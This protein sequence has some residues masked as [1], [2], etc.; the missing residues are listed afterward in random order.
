MKNRR[1]AYIV[2][3]PKTYMNIEE[4]R[5]KYSTD[6]DKNILFLIVPKFL[7]EEYSD[8]MKDT[9]KEK[10][11]DEIIW[12]L[13]WSN[14]LSAKQ[15]KRWYKNRIFKLTW[16]LRETFFNYMDRKNIDQIAHKFAPCDLVFSAHKNT[17]EHLAAKLE[18]VKL[19]LVD[20]GQRIFK[21]INS[22]G[23]IDYSSRYRSL[24]SFRKYLFDFT[25]FKVFDRKK[26]RLF[27]VYADA[28]ETKHNLE[29]NNFEYQNYQFST[30]KVGEQAVWISTPLYSILENIPIENYVSYIKTYIDYLNIDP[31]KLI[32]IPHPGKERKED[33][34]YIQKE[35]KCNVDDRDIPVEFKISNYEELPKICLSPNSSALVNLSISSKN[36]IKIL[37]AWHKDFNEIDLWV[38]WRENVEKNSELTFKFL[39]LENCPPL[40]EH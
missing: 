29:K 23:Y 1:V 4:A 37:S 36:R 5:F 15:K 32:Y 18:P 34:E 14:G 24:L 28:I 6:S 27:T 31:R 11:W 10:L 26:T 19:Y 22:D 25:G 33:V 13:T 16:E 3:D 9:V 20:S 38:S 2:K 39:E 12:I 8:R 30:K 21:R 17:Q 40:F 7:Q 35:L